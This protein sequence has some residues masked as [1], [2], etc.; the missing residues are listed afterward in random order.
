MYFQ[1]SED[2]FKPQKPLDFGTSS[3]ALRPAMYD[4]VTQEQWADWRWQ[5]R[6]RIRK[7]DDLK[8]CFELTDQEVE[9]FVRSEDSFRVAITPHY[10]AL[11]NRQDPA[12][13]LRLQAV[14]Q[15]GELTTYNF[16]L[17]DPLGEEAH[18]PVT[19]ITHRYPDRVL[20]YVSHH[21]P[22]YCRHCTRKRKVSDPN[23]TASRAQLES[24]LD[25]IRRTTS[26][27]DVLLSGGD[28]LTLSDERLGELLKELRAI[29]HVE[30]IRLGTRNPV[31]LPQR[32]TPEL[33][34]LI[35]DFG[36]VYVHTHFNHP[37]ELNTDALAALQMLQ[38]AGAVL[39]NQM[40]LLKG[41]NDSKEVVFTLNRKLLYAGCRP[42][43]MLQCDMAQG[44]THLR[45]PLRKGLE[46]MAYLRGR[47]GGMGVP[48]FVVDLPGGGGK[49]ELLP[50][51]LER[52]YDGPD[53]EVLVFKNWSGERFE[54]VDAG[55]K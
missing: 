16:E 53:G 10:A 31:T 55:E 18:M 8:A 34:Q 29:K 51:Y 21:C 26:V 43:Y 45:T 39:G 24:G 15:E 14:P 19:G 11:M 30:V 2:D 23:T 42:Y 6:H 32:I 33:C 35:K 7:L 22:V 37:D 20:F 13:P 1:A 54:F 48:H 17:E 49:I 25:Y 52:T 40:V 28:P 46:I 44:I 41:V 50:E 9:A 36:P 3:Y 47:I 5:H 38:R 27:R 12:C 4:D